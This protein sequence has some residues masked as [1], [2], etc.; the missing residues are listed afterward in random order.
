MLIT[1]LSKEKQLQRKLFT[2]KALIEKQCSARRHCIGNFKP[3]IKAR[4][5]RFKSW[6]WRPFL[7]VHIWWGANEARLRYE[8]AAAGEYS[9]RSELKAWGSTTTC[10]TFRSHRRRAAKSTRSTSYKMR[11]YA[12]R[13]HQN[14]K[15]G[16]KWGL[17]FYFFSECVWV[18]NVT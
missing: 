2:N 4:K 9:V 17:I 3:F 1:Q 8:A 5:R 10:W 14:A 6:L 11:H 13:T 18:W 12:E 16:F 15:L 7:A